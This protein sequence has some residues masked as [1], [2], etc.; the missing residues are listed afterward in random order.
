MRSLSARKRIYMI[1][2]SRS[3]EI[4]LSTNR[5]KLSP[6]LRLAYCISNHKRINKYLLTDAVV[7]SDLDSVEDDSLLCFSQ[8]VWKRRERLPRL[9]LLTEDEISRS[10]SAET[11]QSQFT[12]N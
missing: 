1:Q 12:K 10:G 8:L 4:R 3:E 9:F 2:N 7:G 5:N 6:H 11:I